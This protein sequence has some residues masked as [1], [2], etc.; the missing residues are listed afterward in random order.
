MFPFRCSP[1]TYLW[2]SHPPEVRSS[3]QSKALKQTAGGL[4]VGTSWQ[5]EVE[6]IREYL[7]YIT[8]RIHVW[9]ICWHFGYIDGKLPYMAY[10]DPMANIIGVG[11]FCES[12][13]W[14]P[15]L[16]LYYPESCGMNIGLDAP[17]I[18]RNHVRNSKRVI[19][20][21]KPLTDRRL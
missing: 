21:S 5:A 6:V 7:W 10:M 14:N 15:L 18:V 16:V 19:F 11:K 12:C 13:V 1:A 9:Y 2:Y 8:H 3:L 4:L 17:Y 20:Q